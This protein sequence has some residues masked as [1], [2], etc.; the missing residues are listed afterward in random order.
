MSPTDLQI[1]GYLNFSLNG[2]ESWKL[3]AA[4]EKRVEDKTKEYLTERVTSLAGP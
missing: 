1:P 3:N 2:Y 4:M